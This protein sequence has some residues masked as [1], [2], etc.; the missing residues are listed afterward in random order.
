MQL[1]P[2]QVVTSYVMTNPYSRAN[3]LIAEIR[4]ASARHGEERVAALNEHCIIGS[5]IPTKS[6]LRGT[7]AR[8]HVAKAFGEHRLGFLFGPSAQL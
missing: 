1:S 5:G 7:D 2:C 6:L 4:S 8:I 3:N